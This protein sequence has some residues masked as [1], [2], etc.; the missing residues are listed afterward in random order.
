MAEEHF[1]LAI[2]GGA[3]ASKDRL[4]EQPRHA[5]PSILA[6]TDVLE[7]PAGHFGQAKGIVKFPVGEKSSV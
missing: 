2:V 3:K 6:G 5:V 7:K 1:D 4:T